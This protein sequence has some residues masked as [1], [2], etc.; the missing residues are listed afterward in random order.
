MANFS[1]IIAK[2]IRRVMISQ[3]TRF[4]VDPLANKKAS[5]L[6]WKMRDAYQKGKYMSSYPFFFP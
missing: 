2:M 6:I 5:G 4:G 1:G 3:G